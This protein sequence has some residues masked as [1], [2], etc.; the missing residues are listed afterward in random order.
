M[1]KPGRVQVSSGRPETGPFAHHRAEIDLCLAML[2]K[3]L[4]I[5]DLMSS[6]DI[7]CAVDAARITIVGWWTSAAGIR[8][9]PGLDSRKLRSRQIEKRPASCET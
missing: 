9:I 8:Q 6:T 2:A 7:T 1:R 5:R 3:R 4:D